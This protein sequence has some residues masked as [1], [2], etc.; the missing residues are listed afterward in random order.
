MGDGGNFSTPGGWARVFG[1][2][3]SLEADRTAAALG[4]EPR[5]EAEAIAVDIVAAARRGDFGEVERLAAKQVEH[6]RHQAQRQ[7]LTT[8]LTLTPIYGGSDIILTAT[9]SNVSAV[10]AHFAVPDS[11]P[12]GDYFVAVSNGAATGELRSFLSE[13]DPWGCS[14]DACYVRTLTVRVA[15]AKSFPS[16]LFRVSDFGCSGG[17]T[18]N[19]SASGMGCAQPTNATAAVHRAIAHAGAAGGG[20]VFFDIGR[21]YVS[22]PLLLPHNVLLKGSGMGL[23]AIYFAEDDQTSAPPA[24]FAPAGH[25]G[26]HMVRYGVED[27][28]VYVLSY[29]RNLFDI[30]VD[31]D[32]V[33]VQR[34]R[35]RANAFHCQ[36]S[37]GQP[38]AARS[39]PWTFIDPVNSNALFTIRGR[40]F[41][42]ADN[43]LFATWQ[44][45]STPGPS[46]N[47]VARGQQY[48]GWNV[49]RFGVIL[50]NTMRHGG[51]CHW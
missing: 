31:T 2:G 51:A 12:A 45:I 20:T 14:Y 27:L 1:R 13:G 23:S 34:V 41:V 39:V 37:M 17:A 28:S 38:L 16:K 15:S 30:G 10:S 48:S 11:V 44:V 18:H 5:I 35:V 42:I 4:P 43:D 22:G 36:D 7:G 40:N 19:C 8:T 26:S 9:A 3:L 46:Y 50:R 29:Y 47:E 6:A 24:Y 32:G 21:W 49:A 33:T 25:N